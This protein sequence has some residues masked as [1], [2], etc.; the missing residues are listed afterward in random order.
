MNLLARCLHLALLC[1]IS[2]A[3]RNAASSDESRAPKLQNSQLKLL[4]WGYIGI[5]ENQME[6]T[7]MENQMENEMETGIIMGYIGLY[8]VLYVDNGKEHGNYYN[9]V[10]Y[11]LYSEM[12][13]V[14]EKPRQQ[15]FPSSM[16]S[17]ICWTFRRSSAARLGFSWLAH[18]RSIN[19]AGRKTQNLLQGLGQRVH[20]R[21]L[22]RPEK[23]KH[24][25][26]CLFCS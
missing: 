2:G 13:A 17:T 6:T 23:Q 21:I 22:F 11:G 8:W 14:Q 12:L 18:R 5:M 16:W 10:I 20:G 9:G 4:Y 26:R 15:A 19:V 24:V 25:N 3:F 7:I 1:G